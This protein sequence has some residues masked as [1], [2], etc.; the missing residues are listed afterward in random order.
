[1]RKFE[2]LKK[3]LRNCHK[4][5]YN[6]HKEFH[7]LHKEYGSQKKEKCTDQREFEKCLREFHKSKIELHRMHR[8]ARI[9]P[10]IILVFN[11][12]I[13]YLVFKYAGIREVSIFFAVLF[14]TGGFFEFFFLRKLEKRILSPIGKLKAGIEEIAAGNYNVKVESETYNQ[15]S[16]LID[17]F[18]EMARKLQESERIK[19]EYEENRKA[20]IANI[21]HDLKT[22]ITSI[23][24]YIEAITEGSI[25]ATEDLSRYLK[26]IHNNAA[27]INK[28]IDDLFFFSKLDMQKLEFEFVSVNVQA[29]MMDLMEEFKLELEEK[30]IKFDYVD[31]LRADY[32]FNIDRKRLHQVFRNI[33][34]NAEKHGTSKGLAI[35]AEV[36][37]IDGFAA[38]KIK[39]N[40]PG[41]SKDKLPHIFERFYR[42]DT[43]RTKDLMS[44]GLGLAI[45]KE[46]IEAHGGQISVSSVEDE[47]SCFTVMLPIIK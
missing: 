20:L 5:S 44:T 11:L 12:L 26:I 17:S 25:S 16:L 2:E 22:P 10:P 27:Y 31:N 30:N 43:E 45:A 8:H 46:L 42:I 29:F 4:E 28:L 24:G 6:C 35:E 7:R 38:I 39:D 37:D 1:M 21:S 3:K 36:S 41:I 47:G 13:W 40:G 9:S 34:G 33:I 14:T 23:Q 15:I 18:N 32:S 19:A